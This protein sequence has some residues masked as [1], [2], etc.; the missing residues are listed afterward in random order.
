MNCTDDRP[1]GVDLSTSICSFMYLSVYCL[2]KSNFNS[3][4]DKLIIEYVWT[5]CRSYS[6]NTIPEAILDCFLSSLVI[7]IF[8]H[9]KVKQSR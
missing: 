2:F 6:V 7:Y 5:T 9:I 4:N 1:K 3:A 8:I